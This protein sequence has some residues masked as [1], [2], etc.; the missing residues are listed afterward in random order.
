M[1]GLFRTKRKLD[2]CPSCLPVPDNGTWGAVKFR[3]FLG[4]GPGDLTPRSTRESTLHFQYISFQ[5]INLAPAS[6]PQA[7]SGRDGQGDGLGGPWEALNRACWHVLFSVESSHRGQPNRRS[8]G[9]QPQRGGPFRVSDEF[10]G[11]SRSRFT[12]S[13]RQNLTQKRIRAPAREPQVLGNA[14]FQI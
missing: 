5:P 14:P 1:C 10:S 3:R 8:R 4:P 13:N 7:D 9:P 12:H 11:S 2:F 6:R